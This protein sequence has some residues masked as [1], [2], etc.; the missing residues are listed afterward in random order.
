MSSRVYL[1]RDFEP[2]PP[3]ASVLNCMPIVWVLSQT[4][5]FFIVMK[6]IQYICQIEDHEVWVK[7]MGSLPHK[8][9]RFGQKKM[10]KRLFYGKA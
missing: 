9:P 2:G 1:V 10:E 3:L 4:V 7:N 5:V 8:S 6:L